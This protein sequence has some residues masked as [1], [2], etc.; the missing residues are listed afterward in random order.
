MP[1]LEFALFE[2]NRLV[3]ASYLALGQTAVASLYGIFDPDDA[4]RSLGT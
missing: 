1:I 3:A 2:H 4:H